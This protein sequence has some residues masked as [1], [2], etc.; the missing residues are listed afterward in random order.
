MI[1]LSLADYEIDAKIRIGMDV[2]IK[3]RPLDDRSNVILSRQS[4]EFLL[5]DL[6]VEGAADDII[7]ASSRNIVKRVVYTEVSNLPH[8]IQF[9][10]IVKL[11]LKIISDLD[12]KYF[13]K[14][15]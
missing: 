5:G 13:C 12:K 15:N 3:F 2:T 14:V 6:T 1:L 10:T 4:R 8:D 11:E 7:V 9:D